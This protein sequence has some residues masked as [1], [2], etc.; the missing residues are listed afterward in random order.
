MEYDREEELGEMYS[1]N[2]S[3][4]YT[5]LSDVHQTLLC[6]GCK[7]LSIETE[8]TVMELSPLTEE[9][10]I[11]LEVTMADQPG[12]PQPPAYSWNGGLVQHALKNDPAMRD[13]KHVQADSPGLV[14]VFFHDRHGYSQPLQ[15]GGPGYALPHCG[16]FCGV[17]REIRT[18]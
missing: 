11:Q 12:R 17:D 15:R 7:M 6:R 16:C 13:L 4:E 3:G 18:L 8:A 9:F 10:I 1:P 5:L 14:Y 2:E